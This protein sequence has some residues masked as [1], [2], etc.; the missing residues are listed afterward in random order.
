MMEELNFNSQ[1]I[2]DA[3]KKNDLLFLKTLNWK[4]I[5]FNTR[6]NDMFYHA[7][8]HGFD[9]PEG[10]YSQVLFQSYASVLK[11]A[12]S[13]E[14]I[15]IL[16][17]N[18]PMEI[19]LLNRLLQRRSV[20]VNI[21]QHIWRK[22]SGLRCNFSATKLN[23]IGWLKLHPEDLASEDKKV[24]EIVAE[25]KARIICV[26]K[27]CT[28]PRDLLLEILTYTEPYERVG[29]MQLVDLYTGKYGRIRKRPR[30]YYED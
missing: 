16:L 3:I 4:K 29:L 24:R 23:I 14:V 25:S 7:Q 10:F 11:E 27:Q 21:L 28:L 8:G 12:K 9:F 20:C 6:K 5:C 18:P 19:E 26:L 22:A 17:N 2:I 30:T 15:D 1:I 13:G